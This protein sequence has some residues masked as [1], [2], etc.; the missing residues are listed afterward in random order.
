[1]EYKGYYYTITPDN[2]PFTGGYYCE[3]FKDENKEILVDDFFLHGCGGK[4]LRSVK[5]RIHETIDKYWWVEDESEDD[6]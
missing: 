6:W 5:R 1:M 4:S 3:V 2:V